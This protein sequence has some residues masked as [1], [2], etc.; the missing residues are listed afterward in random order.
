M[1]LRHQV[2]SPRAVAAKRLLY[3]N[4]ARGNKAGEMAQGK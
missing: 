3:D 2:M 4:S 1:A